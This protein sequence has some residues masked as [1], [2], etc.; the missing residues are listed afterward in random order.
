VT[1][2]VIRASRAFSTGKASLTRA[3]TGRAST[4]K[5]STTGRI[6]AIGDTNG[7]SNLKGTNHISNMTIGITTDDMN[8]INNEKR[9]TTIDELTTRSP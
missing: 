5:T 9:S 3:S 7:K 6:S 1:S 4:G 8:L 2:I